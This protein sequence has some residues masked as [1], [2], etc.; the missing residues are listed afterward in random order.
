MPESPVHLVRK[1]KSEK[2]QEALRRLYT[3]E[4]DAEAHL[5]RI[6]LT[7]HQA[8]ALEQSGS[9]LDCFRFTNRRRTL[10][11][12]IVFL[13]QPMSGLAFV[14]QYGPL[15]Y[16]YMGVDS[17]KSFQL[18]IGAQVLSITGAI[19]SFLVAD[20]V[21][22]RPMFIS[23]CFSLCLL[24]LCMAISGAVPT[25]ASATTAAVAFY[26]MFN[27]FFNAGVGSIVYT[28]AGE[29]PTSALRAKTLA[30]TL[31][32]EAAVNTMWSFVSPYM[33]NPGYGNLKA[34]V[35]FVYGGFMVVFTVLAFL[36]I[37][38]TRRRT[39]EELD[40]LFMNLV[41]ARKFRGYRT[42]AETRAAEAYLVQRKVIGVEVG[43]VG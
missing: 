27:F 42:V 34:K 6:K 11:S 25:S 9:Y 40:E 13:A 29:V 32:L 12:F 2:A 36:Y 30:L 10:I 7:L 5:E 14:Q 1:G 16:Q 22:R 41:P 17:Q 4:N 21:G 35:G 37:P 38:E 33:F 20:L 28:L 31:S 43:E 15:M 19:V 23:G 39:Y 26:T 3:Q 24:L 8:E 18:Q